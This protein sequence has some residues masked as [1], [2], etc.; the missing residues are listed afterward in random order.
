M[1]NGLG[2][3]GIMDENIMIHYDASPMP[4]D[5]GGCKH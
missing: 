2:M 5:A 1:Q 3:C 4:S